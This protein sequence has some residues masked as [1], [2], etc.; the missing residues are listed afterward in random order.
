MERK[1]HERIEKRDDR[2]RDREKERERKGRKGKRRKR[3]RNIGLFFST[4]WS[5]KKS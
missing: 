5:L 1:K 2:E 4:E 3:K